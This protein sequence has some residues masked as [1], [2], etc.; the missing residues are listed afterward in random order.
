MSLAK[1]IDHIIDEI[2]SLDEQGMDELAKRIKQIK[3]LIE[4]IRD[5]EEKLYYDM[6]NESLKD[7]WENEKDE[8]Y[9]DL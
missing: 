6:V 4:K 3:K 5:E 8:A 7:V 9:N 1:K 2:Y